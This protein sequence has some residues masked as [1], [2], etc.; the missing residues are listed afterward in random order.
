ML[1]FCS[2]ILLLLA[3]GLLSN[4]LAAQEKATWKEMFEFHDVMSPA[5][6]SAEVGK[7]QPLREKA[8]LLYEKAKAWKASPVPKGYHAAQTADTLKRLV[9][10]CKTIKK[11]VKAKKSDA[12]LTAMIT[13]AHDIFHEIMEKCR[14]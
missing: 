1:K 4:S 5:F 12:E 11:A 7:L 3:F 13:T 8:G 2:G 10:Q 9:K 14:E 6:H